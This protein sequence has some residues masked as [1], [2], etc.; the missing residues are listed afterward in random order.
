MACHLVWPWHPREEA[1]CRRRWRHRWPRNC[2]G[3]SVAGEDS[4]PG[5]TQAGVE[6]TASGAVTS[7]G[8][9]S[10]HGRPAGAK[11]ATCEEGRRA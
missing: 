10:R 7:C 3:S 8:G 1:M 4:E 5:S 11:T 9:C 6:A 2:D